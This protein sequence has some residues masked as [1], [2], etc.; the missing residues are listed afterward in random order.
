MKLIIRFLTTV[1]IC[2]LPLVSMAQEPQ[3]AATPVTKS[4]RWF[5]TWEEARKDS[6][7]KEQPRLIY[8]YNHRARPCKIMQEQTFTDPRV[9]ELLSQFSCVALHNEVNRELAKR[10]QLVKVPTMIFVDTQGNMIDR[11]VGVK[12]PSDFVLYLERIKS[13]SD[14]AK[15]A[16]KQV[17]AFT[18]TP[19]DIL[20]PGKNTKAVTL[21]Y[22]DPGARKVGIVGDFNDW[23]TPGVPLVKNPNGMW[24]TVLHLQDGVYE[25]KYYV[26][27]SDWK[28]DNNNPLAQANPYGEA[29]SIIIV[30]NAKTS[31][32]ISNRNVSFIIYNT[33]AKKIEVAGTFN[34]W[35]QLEMFRNP[36]DAGMWGVRYENLAPGHYEYKFIV[37]GVWATDLE[38]YTAIRDEH[39]NWNS[40]FD[41]R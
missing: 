10:F 21:R 41:I 19:V 32:I 39:G 13:A 40:S 2:F 7:A 24:E 9:I 17:D 20:R 4:I 34:G 14:K 26:N 8:F 6:L 18:N 15:A 22:S 37:D 12:A 3:A 29:N 30:G 36:N 28:Q 1:Y 35:Q 25:Y 16:K 31:P 27:D 33:E 38:N 11:A 23:R 5:G